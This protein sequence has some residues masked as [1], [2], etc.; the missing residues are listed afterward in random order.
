MAFTA[1]DILLD[2][3]ENSFCRI[4]GNVDTVGT[5]SGEIREAGCRMPVVGYSSGNYLAQALTIPVPSSGKWFIEAYAIERGSGNL[6]LLVLLIITFILIGQ[7]HH[8]L[9]ILIQ[10]INFP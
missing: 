4:D 2:H 8:L 10:F 7:I 1:N 6:V 3:P 9:I 5:R